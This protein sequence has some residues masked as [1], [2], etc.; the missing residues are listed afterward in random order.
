M[1]PVPE[2]IVTVREAVVY[3]S[4]IGATTGWSGWLD[5]LTDLRQQD[6]PPANTFYYGV[7]SPD[8]SFSDYCRGGC[9][10][11]LGWVPGADTD[12]LRASVGVSFPDALNVYTSLHEVGHTM[13]RSHAPCGGPSGVDPSYPYSGA[14]IG[15]WGYDVVGDTLKDPNV[16]TDIMGYCQDQWISDYTYEE[17]FDRISYANQQSAASV[18]APTR[19]RVGLV[20]GDGNIEW[21]RYTDLRRPLVGDELSI[22]LLDQNGGE[23]ELV[24]GHFFPYDHLDGGMLMVP[25]RAGTIPAQIRPAGLQT[26]T[27]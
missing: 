8:D 5:T 20:D 10:T 18:S 3:N 13:G 22:A 2:V 11:G 26:L 17:I 7:A 23:I 19:Y 1:Y 24:Q 14:S 27:W 25:V 15:V 12:Y 21:R 9:I 16:Y 4:S 6:N